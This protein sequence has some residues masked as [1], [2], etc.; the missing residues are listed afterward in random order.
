MARH[1]IELARREARRR[2]LARFLTA[3]Q[4]GL[5]SEHESDDTRRGEWRSNERAAV[6]RGLLRILPNSRRAP[7]RTARKGAHCWF[8]MEENGARWIER[9]GRRE[10]QG[11]SMEGADP[12]MACSC[13]QLCAES[14]PRGRRAEEP[15]CWAPAMERKTAGE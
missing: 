8:S 7:R 2:P 14:R 1:P 11:A 13:S 9:A 4:M 12:A 10:Q 5:R 15:S 3:S 6:A